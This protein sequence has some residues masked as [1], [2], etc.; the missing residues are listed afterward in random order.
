MSIDNGWG[1]DPDSKENKSSDK[2]DFN[3]LAI[4]TIKKL[5]ACNTNDPEADHSKADKLLCDFLIEL[6]YSDVVKEWNKIK[7][8]YA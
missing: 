6:G 2:P 3:L 7:K 4:Q 8:Y 5:E 1:F